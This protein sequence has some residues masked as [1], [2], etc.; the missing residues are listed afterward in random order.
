MSGDPVRVELFVRPIDRMSV[1]NIFYAK[2]FANENPPPHLD[3]HWSIG[4]PTYIPHNSNAS[5]A[6]PITDKSAEH[7]NKQRAF[8]H[9]WPL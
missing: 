4:N 3:I 8:F 9:F 1:S 7:A 6:F 5:Q 2:G